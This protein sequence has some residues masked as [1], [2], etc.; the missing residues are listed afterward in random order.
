MAHFAGTGPQNK[1]CGEC[2]FLVA[3]IKR[4]VGQRCD[5]YRQMMGEYGAAHIPS[6]TPACKY[7]ARRDA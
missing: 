3:A 4:Q 6:A 7:F 2:R 5:K 1:T